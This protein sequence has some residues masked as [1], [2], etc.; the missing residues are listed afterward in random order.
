MVIEGDECVRVW[1]AAEAMVPMSKFLRS[2][3]PP[4][5]AAPPFFFPS[6]HSAPF[7]SRPFAHRLHRLDPSLH[8]AGTLGNR[9]PAGSAGAER[10]GD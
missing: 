5:P 9:V 1:Q 6:A 4:P 10:E 3:V 8:L 2:V 7:V